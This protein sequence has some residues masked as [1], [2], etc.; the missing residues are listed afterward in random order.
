MRFLSSSALWWMLTG[1][2]IILFYL[3]KLKRKRRVVSS[4]ILWHRALEEMEANAPLK[5]LRRSL[6]RLSRLSFR[7]PARL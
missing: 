7:L 4:V 5:R 1:A 6:W 3:L 2:I